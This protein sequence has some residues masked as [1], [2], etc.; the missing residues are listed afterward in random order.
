MDLQYLLNPAVPF[1]WLINHLPVERLKWH[2]STVQINDTNVLENILVRSNQF[3][4][5]METS[6][7]L[8]ILPM[9]IDSGMWLL[10]LEN[11]VPDT[12]R[13]IEF[14]LISHYLLKNGF[15][16]QYNLPHKGETAKFTCVDNDWI[17][18]VAEIDSFSSR[19]FC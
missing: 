13:N 11:A 16:S 3:E 8:E 19:I 2:N 17:E 6:Q 1:V 7:F 18:R 4:M 10:Q 15:Y 5:M 14:P 12:L 9:F